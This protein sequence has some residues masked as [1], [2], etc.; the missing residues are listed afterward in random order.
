MDGSSRSA[1]PG[2]WD[3]DD[4]VTVGGWLLRSEV[5]DELR[6]LAREWGQGN[7]HVAC[8]LMDAAAS[9]EGTL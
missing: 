1:P 9:F 7:D 8:A 5:V 6:R 3:D 4:P 2:P